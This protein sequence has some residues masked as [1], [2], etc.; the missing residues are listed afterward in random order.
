[1]KNFFTVI[2]ILAVSIFIFAIYYTSKSLYIRYKL[3]SLNSEIQKKRYEDEKKY[4]RNYI[5]K[6]LN[7]LKSGKLRWILI[8]SRLYPESKLELIYN[9]FKK[10]IQI[11][12]RIRNIS[13]EELKALKNLGLKDYKINNDLYCIDVSLNSKIVTDIIYFI[14]ERLNGQK[15]AHNIKIVTSGG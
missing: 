10:N 4:I 2:L 15:N 1:M 12:H 13:S 6:L 5:R 11:Q 9:S 14:F 8:S 7:D 3:R